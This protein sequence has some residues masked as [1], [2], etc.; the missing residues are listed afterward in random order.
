MKRIKKISQLTDNRYL[1]MYHVQGENRKQDPVN[2]YVA[3]RAKGQADLKLAK[4]DN[5]PDGVLVYSLHGEK[6][7][8][9]VLVRQYRYS[10]D[11]Y[12]YEFPAGLVESGED[13]HHAAVREMKEETGLELNVLDVDACYEKPYF[14][15][16]GMS[17]ESCA[18]VYGY[19]NG[20]PSL[21]YL[22]D[23]EDLQVVLADRDEVRRILKEEQVSIMCA[24]MLMHFLQDDDGFGFLKQ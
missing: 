17:D 7:D 10:L 4:R 15:S 21:A 22:E 2:Y 8:K 23:D 5:Q 18:T 9:V 12:I 11:N 13:F 3:S 19:T 16:I 14:T 24:Y 1:N 20:E 6:R